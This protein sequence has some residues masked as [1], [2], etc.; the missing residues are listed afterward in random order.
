MHQEGIHF[1]VSP[2]QKLEDVA[3]N[4]VD[5]EIFNGSGCG[6]APSPRSEDCFDAAKLWGTSIPTSWRSPFPALGEA[7][8]QEL[9]ASQ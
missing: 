1:P 8:F 6:P 2:R 9:P 4:V 5:M 7:H 3:M